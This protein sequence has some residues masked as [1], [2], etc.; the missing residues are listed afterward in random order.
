MSDQSCIH[1]IITL[2]RDR[3][4]QETTRQDTISSRS[5]PFAAVEAILANSQE[6]RNSDGM[7]TSVTVAFS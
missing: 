2:R 6:Q 7:L 3:L 5:N 4:W 1:K